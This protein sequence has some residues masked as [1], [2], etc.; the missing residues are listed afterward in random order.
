M[1]V[2]ESSQRTKMPDQPE[3]HIKNIKGGEDDDVPYRI[4]KKDPF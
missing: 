3:T 2:A 1:S 4:R